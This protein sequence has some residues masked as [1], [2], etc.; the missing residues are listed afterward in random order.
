MDIGSLLL[1]LALVVVIVFIVTRPL[2]EHTGLRDG[3]ASPADQLLG[4][5]ERVLI[6]LRDLDFDSATGKINADDY[7]AQR[8]QLVAEGVA[9][10]KQLD[11]L[12][13]PLS[14]GEAG[15]A[16]AAPAPALV[17]TGVGADP[18]DEIESAVAQLR[19][20]RA[21]PAQPTKARP[22]EHKRVSVDAEIEATIAQR[23]AAGPARPVAAKL[24]CA[25]CGT[26]V[27]PNDRFCPKCGSPQTI[28]CGNCG[29]VARAG[30]Q[31]C[32]QC[33]QSLPA[34]AAPALPARPAKVQ[35]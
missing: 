32:A 2:V 24:A 35:G 10:L 16:P 30:D 25:Q 34:A 18:A 1:G 33:G 19:A 14:A 29:T 15:A 13:A 26:A 6:Q 4:R 11:A 17:A 31:F 22:A 27:L 5:R 28:A 8:A 3:P 9:L 21:A 20:R 7:A 23:R 12:G